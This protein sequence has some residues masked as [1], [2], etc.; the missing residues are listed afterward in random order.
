V[1]AGIIGSGS[2]GSFSLWYVERGDFNWSNIKQLFERLV[3][4]E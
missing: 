1:A 2:C 3:R 4:G